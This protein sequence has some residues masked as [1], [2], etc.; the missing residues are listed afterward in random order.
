VRNLDDALAKEVARV[1]AQ[2]GAGQDRGRS[3]TVAE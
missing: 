3:I 1:A 2:V